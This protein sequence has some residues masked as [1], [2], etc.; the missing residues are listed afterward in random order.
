M[1]TTHG[2]RQIGPENE[3]RL[4]AVLQWN[5]TKALSGAD[6]AQNFLPDTFELVLAE[7]LAVAGS[8]YVHECR[9][10]NGPGI[11]IPG[12]LGGAGFERWQ[13]QRSR[14]QEADRFVKFTPIFLRHDFVS[15]IGRFQ[16]TR[17]KCCG[18]GVA[19]KSGMS[20]SK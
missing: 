17:R 5:A 7:E 11:A 12:G 1:C 6:I 15:S 14:G 2:S 18:Q 10:G 20:S 3:S 4:I 19:K 13:T 16:A 8:D 9:S